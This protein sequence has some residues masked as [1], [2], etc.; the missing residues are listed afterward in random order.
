MSRELSGAAPAWQ[1]QSPEFDSRTRRGKKK[2]GGQRWSVQCDRS[3]KSV[4]EI[5]T[6]LLKSARRKC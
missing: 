1:A 5:Q 2:G 6:A 4:T 3:L